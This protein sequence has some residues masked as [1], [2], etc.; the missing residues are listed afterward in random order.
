[1]QDDGSPR[2]QWIGENIR[3]AFSELGA[4]ETVLTAVSRFEKAGWGLSFVVDWEPLEPTLSGWLAAAITAFSGA[5]RW[6][7]GSAFNER[8]V[9]V[10]AAPLGARPSHPFV[11]ALLLEH[12]VEVFGTYIRGRIKSEGGRVSGPKPPTS[13]L[14]RVSGFSAYDI[15]LVRRTDAFQ[16]D[17]ES[18]KLLPTSPDDRQLYIA[19]R[20]EDLDSVSAELPTSQPVLP[21]TDEFMSRL[22]YR[23]LR[24]AVELEL[25]A[26]LSERIRSLLPGLGN[27]VSR[28]LIG[29]I[30]GILD[31]ATGRQMGVVFEPTR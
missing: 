27:P 29:D 7:A 14:E 17:P 2:I 30:C 26:S 11:S 8:G 21:G 1:M 24:V 20:D 13:T 12:E 9:E 23:H 22:F 28:R 3:S 18:D 15:F 5:L 4:V 6:S 25:T 10:S 16:F 19:I 31:E